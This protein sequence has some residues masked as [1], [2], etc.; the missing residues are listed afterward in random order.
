[1]QDTSI[2][3]ES[4]KLGCHVSVI[5]ATLSVTHDRVDWKILIFC[6][7]NYARKRNERDR[8]RREMETPRERD[9]SSII[10]Q[11]VVSNFIY[12]ISGLYTRQ[13]LI[14]ANHI[15]LK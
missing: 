7:V 6:I 11:Y 3:E 14:K 5:Q 15:E 8:L 12:Y 4:D 10:K 1:L 9:K 13:R 2:S